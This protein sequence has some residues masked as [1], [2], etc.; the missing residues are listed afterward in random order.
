[1]SNK[2]I[3][4]IAITKSFFDS[5]LLNNREGQTINRLIISLLN[6]NNCNVVQTVL[7]VDIGYNPISSNS[8]MA[9]YYYL[10]KNDIKDSQICIFEASRFSP[11]L[12][13]ELINSANSKKPTLVLINKN[14]KDV[15]ATEY[16]LFEEEYP[17]ISVQEYTSEEL[18][19]IIKNFIELS[20]K[21]VPNARFTVRLSETMDNYLE[22][23]KLELNC[24]SKNEAV[25]KILEKSMQEQG[26]I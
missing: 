17:Y 24:S 22:R 7:G 3:K 4:N 1:M 2:I 12:L 10:K 15:N 6:K 16:K 13:L 5:S 19:Q 18:D 14:S 25:I 21:M 9:N 20:K 23:L 26:I 8:G 11:S